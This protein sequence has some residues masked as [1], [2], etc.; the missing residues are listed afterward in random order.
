MASKKL[1]ANHIIRIIDQFS[2]VQYAFIS[3][4]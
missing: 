4:I 3:I 1:A 2:E